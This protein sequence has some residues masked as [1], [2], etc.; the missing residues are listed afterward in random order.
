M[1]QQMARIE[2]VAGEVWGKKRAS[3]L[4]AAAKE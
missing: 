2:Y 4:L 3:V 1:T